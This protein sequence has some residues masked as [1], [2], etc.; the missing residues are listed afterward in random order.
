M[1]EIWWTPLNDSIS[2][3]KDKILP[4]GNLNKMGELILD[5]KTVEAW[6]TDEGFICKGKGPGSNIKVGEWYLTI[7]SDM[8]QY[9]VQNKIAYLSYYESGNTIHWIQIGPMNHW[10]WQIHPNGVMQKSLSH[11]S[12]VEWKKG[13]NT[14]WGNAYHY[15]VP[16]QSLKL[17]PFINWKVNPLNGGS[18]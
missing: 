3:N 16:M 12:G 1:S 17:W 2:R 6:M 14:S 11:L 15:K 9:T 7:P 13:G 10:G 8:S 18:A 5:S 4:F